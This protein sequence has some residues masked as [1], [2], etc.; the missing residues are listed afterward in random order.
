[1]LPHAAAAGCPQGQG[2]D[3]GCA[4]RCR[5]RRSAARRWPR[6]CWCACCGRVS[7]W[8]RQ[9]MGQ[10]SRPQTPA[11]EGGQPA[12]SPES[13]GALSDRRRSG[14]CGRPAAW[15]WGP[16]ERA[17]RRHRPSSDR[18]SRVAPVASR[19]HRGRHAELHRP[20]PRQV[21]QQLRKWRGLP[22][23]PRP[24]AEGPPEAAQTACHG[25][26]PLGQDS[27]QPHVHWCASLE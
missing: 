14:R 19:P 2:A 20:P 27:L 18:G 5:Q 25:T 17:A 15:P 24:P 10:R 7:R 3:V 13:P 12:G 26:E 16:G 22:Q 8:T 23:W 1:M 9:R 6:C 4:W 11:G 21:P